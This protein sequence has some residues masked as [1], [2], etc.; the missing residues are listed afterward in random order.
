MARGASSQT[1]GPDHRKRGNSQTQGPDYGKRG[2]KSKT[3]S[4]GWLEGREVKHRVNIMVR[5]FAIRGA[6]P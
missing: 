2:E 3:G 4:K 1:Q 5:R 6:L